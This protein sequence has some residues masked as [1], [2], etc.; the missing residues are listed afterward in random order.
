MRG[1]Q[2]Q[3]GGVRVDEPD[4][5]RDGA[6]DRADRGAGR[7]RRRAAARRARAARVSAPREQHA[8]RDGERDG[9]ERRRLA[10]VERAGRRAATGPR[11]AG[12]AP[13]IPSTR[14]HAH[15]SGTATPAASVQANQAPVAQ[16]APARAEERVERRQ[17]R[18]QQQAQHEQPDAPARQHVAQRHDPVRSRRRTAAASRRR[19]PRRPASSSAM[20]GAQRAA[21]RL[22]R[23]ARARRARR[24]AGP[25]SPLI[26]SS[27]AGQ[28]GAVDLALLGDRER[29]RAARPL[30]AGARAARIRA[31][32]LARPPPR[33]CAASR[34]AAGRARSTTAPPTACCQRAEAR[35]P[36]HEHR[37]RSPPASCSR[38]QARAPAPPPLPPEVETSTSVLRRSR[39][40]SCGLPGSPGSCSLG[41]RPRAEDARQ[42]EQRRGARQ[43]G[44]PGRVERVAVG[45]HDD[46]AARAARAA[47][48]RRSRASVSPSTVRP[49]A[50][51]RVTREAGGAEDLRPRGRRARRRRASR[52]AARGNAAPSCSSESRTRSLAVRARRVEGVR[53][54]RACAAATG[55][56]WS[57][58]ATTNSASSAGRKAA[59]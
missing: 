28:P 45:E 18:G 54:R 35:S 41:R 38:A 32:L 40:I 2:Q 4:G 44:E 25:R 24:G 51:V 37:R 39:P 5:E 34:A 58:N 55:R 3:R 49:R 26:C 14:S 33:P 59:R 16:P 1:R 8:R 20:H 12:S 36:E 52:G 46:A 31:D 48:R 17:Q 50:V 21:A 47:R 43:V 19:T 9:R 13:A 30:G 7:A 11:G 53:D 42:L 27:T 15:A 57:E 23:S 56:P 22:G 10:R 6:D 29:Q